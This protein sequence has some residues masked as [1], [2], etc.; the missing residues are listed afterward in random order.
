[1]RGT[2]PA[3]SGQ[4]RLVTGTF[5]RV[6]FANF[7]YFMSIGALGP[8]MPRYVD[9]PLGGGKV[10]V[11]LAVGAFTVTALILRPFSGRFGDRRGRR[12]PIIAGLA[13]HTVSLAMLLVADTLVLVIVARLVTGVGEALFFVGASAAIQDLA[14]DDRRAEAASLFSLSLFVGLGIGPLV[15]EGLLD[16]FG[17]DAVWLFA[18]AVS[19]AGAL[20]TLSVPDTRTHSNDG[21]S[22]RL[23]HGAALRPGLILGCAIWGLAAFNNFMP[24]YALDIGLKGSRYVFLTNA[25][26]IFLFRSVG[27]KIPDRIGALRA[28]RLSLACTPIGMAILSLW[29]DPAALYVSAVFQGMGQSLAFPALMSIAINNAAPNERGAVMGTF[30]AFFDLSFGGGSMVLGAIASQLGFRGAFLTSTAVAAAGFM[31]VT[32]APPRARGPIREV[33]PVLEISPPGE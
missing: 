7:G 11:G 21:G 27:A 12:I 13:I 30:T 8:V 32:F 33:G 4:T 16:R 2:R 1:M 20:V 28:A 10:G 5:L 22:T 9:G 18:T 19:I 23:L 15:G 26:V 25:V 3:P 6:T 14:P 29:A 17:Y 31:I 24:L